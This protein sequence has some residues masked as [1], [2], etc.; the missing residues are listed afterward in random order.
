MNDTWTDT[1][2]VDGVVFVGDAA[3]WSDPVIGQG[4]SVAFRDAHLV[5][6]VVTASGDWSPAAFG[7]YAEERK[8][9]MRRLRFAC[10]GINLLNDFGPEA[11]ERRGRLFES[12]VADPGA[13][14]LTTALL[15]AWVLPEEAYSDAAWDVLT[16][17]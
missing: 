7:G 2:V 3:G 5:T 9:R 10:A 6:E 17:V 8:E 16:S 4:M 12:F 14:P 1:V 11:R 15:G 13:S